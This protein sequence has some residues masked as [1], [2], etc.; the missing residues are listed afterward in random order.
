MNRIF[1]I[2][3]LFNLNAGILHCQP[4]TDVY[5]QFDDAEFFYSTEEYEEALYLF[6]QLYRDY[7]ENHN[8]N[9]K[10]GMCYLNIPG[11]ERNAIK[12]FEKAVDNTTLKYKEHDFTIKKA[13][14]H[15][16]F[17]L[18]NAYRINNELD[19]ALDSYIKFQDIRNFEK[20]Y[21]LAIV[22]NEVNACERAKIIQDNP[23]NLVLKNLGESINTGVKAY[24]PV[25]NR[26]ESVLAFMQ[27]QR[28]YDA[29]MFSEKVNGQWTV[30]V[31]ITPQVG[32]DG[33]M[34]P[35]AFSDDGKSLL[36]IKRTNSS[37]GDIYISKRE[38]NLWN[39]AKPLDKNIN[40]SR[41]EAH[42]SFSEDGNQIILS[43]ARRGGYGG[44]DLYTSYLKTDGT[45]TLPQNLGELINT[46]YDESSAFLMNGGKTLY[47][48]S[49]G[50]FNMGGYDI[51][52]S[53]LDENGKWTD[54]VNIGYPLNTT[55]DNS[56]YQP[57]GNGN[58]GYIALFGQEANFGEEDIYRIEV[59]P[60]TGPKV[61][62]KAMFDEDFTILIENE[63]SGEII[64]LKYDR[65]TDQII[66][67]SNQKTKLKWTLKKR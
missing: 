8:L 13:P 27:E 51:F 55:N 61:P 25:V 30:P 59:L 58:S 17:Y 44:L 18:G 20:K 66:L 21:N 3:F 65:K 38:G 40:S 43:S 29:I 34:V 67:N 41:D 64:E 57:V 63:E 19:K 47:F 49:R 42:A 33:D 14:H 2:F 16:W 31:N 24:Q 36:L 39:I 26:S 37:D 45:W 62:E 35:A 28:F 11:Q 23:I 22:Q 56:F 52:F 10:I 15:A 5:Q 54:P 32:S 53:N 46:E 60:F 7:P 4:P 12:Y 48:T 6:Q 1:F 50:H 9:F